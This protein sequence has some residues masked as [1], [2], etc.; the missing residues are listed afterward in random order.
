MTSSSYALVRIFT[1]EMAMSGDRTL[2]E[3]LF[4]LARARGLR[5]GTAFRAFAGF[6]RPGLGHPSGFIDHNN[7]L[8][9]DIIDEEARLLAFA[10]EISSL[11]GIGLVAIL[12]ITA[13]FGG[14]QA[15]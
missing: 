11:R 1:D 12:P 9:V 14:V 4:D 13:V 5:G 10:E 2:V 3:H 6:G 15:D 8:V 7:P